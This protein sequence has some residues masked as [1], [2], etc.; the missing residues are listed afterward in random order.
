VTI[1]VRHKEESNYTSWKSLACIVFAMVNLSTRKIVLKFSQKRVKCMD[2]QKKSYKIWRFNPLDG[3][4]V[5]S[6]AACKIWVLDETRKQK[7]M[8]RFATFDRK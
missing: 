6:T 5:E 7:N 1:F 3:T 4:D 8:A 2:K